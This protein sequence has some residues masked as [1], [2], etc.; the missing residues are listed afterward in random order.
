MAVRLAVLQP[1]GSA[2]GLSACWRTR[3]A[4]WA[5]RGG[6]TRPALHCALTARESSHRAWLKPRPSLT[7]AA[8]VATLAAAQFSFN[9][10]STS[11]AASTTSTAVAATSLAAAA[12]AAATDPAM[13]ATSNPA[14]S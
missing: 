10:L 7:H 3:R 8:L 12:V 5:R 13:S 2:A 11:L 9:A 14:T 4:A 1:H 6:Q